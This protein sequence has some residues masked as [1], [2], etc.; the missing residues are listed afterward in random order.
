MRFA[1]VEEPGGMGRVGSR[2]EVGLGTGATI[3]KRVP[4]PAMGIARA[5]S[6]APPNRRSS[7]VRVGSAP[8]SVIR[9]FFFTDTTPSLDSPP[10]RA[11]ADGPV[12]GGSS[13]EEWDAPR[14]RAAR[15]RVPG[16][17]SGPRRFGAVSYSHALFLRMQFWQHGR[18][19]SHLILRERLRRVSIGPSG[20]GDERG[21]ASS[22]SN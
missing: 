18:V 15:L 10:E 5:S 1:T 21:R 7:D 12:A 6:S 8:P 3:C 9:R 14:L 17:L 11:A 16:T 22:G 2:I 13:S 4:L 19:E 20:C